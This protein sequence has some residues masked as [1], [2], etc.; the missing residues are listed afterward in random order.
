MAKWADYLISQVSYDQDHIITKVMQHRDIGN[1]ISSGEIVD[2]NVIAT[3]L[4]HGDKYMTM[5]GGLGKIRMGKNVRYFRAYDDHFIRI[6][7][8]K[9]MS[10]NLGQ[11]PQL[12]G[13]NQEE[14]P[15]LTNTK[16]KPAV[17]TKPLSELSSAFFA[18]RVEEPVK[19]EAE[20][21]PVKV[22][23]EVE[24][25]PITKKVVKTKL[26]TKKKSVTKK[27]PAKK[28]SV[29]K[30]KPAKKKRA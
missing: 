6:D 7:D 16:P 1:K 29:T 14:K 2:R 9:V 25:E 18:E 8:N 11:I 20:V 10:D 26:P 3:N 19:V 21:E 17:E 15:A 28:K 4:G 13:T 22:E 12:N 23:A 24:P 27:K 30:K 5:F